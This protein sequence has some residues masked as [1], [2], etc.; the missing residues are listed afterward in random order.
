M[1]QVTK[2]RNLDLYRVWVEKFGKNIE[3]LDKTLEKI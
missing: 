3:L 1:S 2:D